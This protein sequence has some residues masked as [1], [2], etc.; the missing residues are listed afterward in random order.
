MVP[1]KACHVRYCASTSIHA[2]MTLLRAT[3]VGKAAHVGVSAGW[4]NGP[5]R[6]PQ[7]TV[8]LQR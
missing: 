7:C 1:H 8:Q 3:K 2:S 4:P 6:H 5:S